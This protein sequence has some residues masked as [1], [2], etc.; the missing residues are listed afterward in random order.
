MGNDGYCYDHSYGTNSL[1]VVCLN[2]IGWTDGSSTDFEGVFGVCT[3]AYFKEGRAS[4]SLVVIEEKFVSLD[5]F[6]GLWSFDGW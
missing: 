4:G 6:K 1:R 3:E 5:I 2:I